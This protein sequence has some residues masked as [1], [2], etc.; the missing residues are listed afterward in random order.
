MF[1][2]LMVSGG[3][4]CTNKWMS[5]HE[6]SAL[7]G[8]ER[9]ASSRAVERGRREERESSPSHRFGLLTLS[10]P[11]PL[12]TASVFSAMFKCLIS[13]RRASHPSETSP[14]MKLFL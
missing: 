1:V 2:P 13:F 6:G 11:H 3:D 12:L 10:A 5:V 8:G 9:G 7:T 4:S 14:A